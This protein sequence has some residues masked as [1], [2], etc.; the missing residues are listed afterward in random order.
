MVENARLE[1]DGR[2]IV[3]HIPMKFKRRGGRKE[4]ILPDSIQPEKPPTP[5]QLAIARAHRWQKMLDSG[6]AESIGALAKRLNMDK[7]FLGRMLRL[8]LLAPDIIESLLAR[9]EQS[10]LSLTRL[11]AAIPP[12]WDEQRRDYDCGCLVS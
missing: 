1:E 2:I 3:I 9:T 5:L 10:A 6:E 7:A 11:L 12:R 4:I 8:T